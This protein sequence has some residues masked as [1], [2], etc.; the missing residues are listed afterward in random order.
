MDFGDTSL[1]DM[2]KCDDQPFGGVL[3]ASSSLQILKR[4]QPNMCFPPNPLKIKATKDIDLAEP[5]DLRWNF[6]FSQKM[7][8]HEPRSPSLSGV[9]LGRDVIRWDGQSWIFRGEAERRISSAK[10]EWVRNRGPIESNS[11]DKTLCF[12]LTI[13]G[14]DF[15]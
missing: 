2:E 8:N 6:S 14:D 9:D 11:R 7:G 3:C 10:G 4:L 12:S 13:L 1:S 5:L 15:R